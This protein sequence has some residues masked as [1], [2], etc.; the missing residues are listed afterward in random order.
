LA[1]SFIRAHH[2]RCW[3]LADKRTQPSNGRYWTNSGQTS[4]R[5]LNRCVL[6]VEV[7]LPVRVP[8]ARAATSC[9][10]QYARVWIWTIPGRPSPPTTGRNLPRSLHRMENELHADWVLE[11]RSR[12]GLRPAET[13]AR[14]Y[15]IAPTSSGRFEELFVR[16]PP[17]TPPTILM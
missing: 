2:V 1:A 13:L 15:Q 8:L 6:M 14:Q 16:A 3:H 17:A 12:S 10:A 4:A 5:R 9:S 11:W 7:F